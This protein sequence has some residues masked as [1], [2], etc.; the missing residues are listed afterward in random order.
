MNARQANQERR[1]VLIGVL[2]ALGYSIPALQNA[3]TTDLEAEWALNENAAGLE[4]GWE[5][6][7][8]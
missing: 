4:P 2:A 7:Q 3:A 8:A 1:S 5:V 6:V